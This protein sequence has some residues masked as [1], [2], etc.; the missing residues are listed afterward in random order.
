MG[1]LGSFVGAPCE[2]WFFFGA[3]RR[4]LL[5]LRC[6]WV[7]LNLPFFDIFNITYKKKKIIFNI[8]VFFYINYF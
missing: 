6:N 3:L 7:A 5:F 4:S 2:L 8:Y 1:L